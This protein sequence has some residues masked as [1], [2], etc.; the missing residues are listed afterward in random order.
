MRV[1]VTT[2]MLPS[3]ACRPGRR[4]FARVFPDGIDVEWTPLHS[5][6]AASRFRYYKWLVDE[7]LIPVCDLRGQ[8]LRGVD[9]R[10]LKVGRAPQGRAKLD[11]ALVNEGQWL[12]QGWEA[13]EGR[14]RR[15]RD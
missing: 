8:D 14:V 1:Q 13:A 11:G 15:A 10:R 5:V 9:L 6:W 2:G 4:Q 12:P 3:E 7:G